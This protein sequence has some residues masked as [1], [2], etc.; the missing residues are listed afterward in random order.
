M[1]NHDPTP[2]QSG[3][4]FTERRVEHPQPT[5]PKP[6]GAKHALVGHYGRTTSSRHDLR[7]AF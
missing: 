7:V 5:A 1:A 4:F 2:R 6:C 3:L